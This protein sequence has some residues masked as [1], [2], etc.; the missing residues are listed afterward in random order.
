MVGEQ[1]VS[2]LPDYVQS[3]VTDVYKNAS[4]R[5]GPVRFEWVYDGT[6]VWVV[7]LHRGESISAGETIVPGDESTAYI[8]YQTETG[9]D[10][11]RALIANHLPGTGITLVGNVGIS[12][13][14][15]DLLRKANIPSRIQRKSQEKSSE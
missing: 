4:G 7:Q 9:I 3:A 8:P 12:S 10:G 2:A 5:L 15:G 6:Q 11:L 13:H 1:G 14:M